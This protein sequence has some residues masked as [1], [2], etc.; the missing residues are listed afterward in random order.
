MISLSLSYTEKLIVSKVFKRVFDAAIEAA[1]I[2]GLKVYQDT[3]EIVT[4]W[5]IY[6]LGRDYFKQLVIEFKKPIKVRANVYEVIGSTAVYTIAH[7]RCNCKASQFN[8]VC[9][10][11]RAYWEVA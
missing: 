4:P 3:V 11:L 8:R 9:K 1:E 5:G 2:V 6:S 7:G 10:H